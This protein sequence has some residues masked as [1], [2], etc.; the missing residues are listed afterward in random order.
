MSGNEQSGARIESSRDPSGQTLLSIRGRLDSTSAAGVW[1]RLLELGRAAGASGLVVDASA[2]EY[3]DGA[4][5]SL[6]VA[7]ERQQREAGGGFHVRGLREEF[8]KL[9]E[10]IEPA[11]ARV[12]AAPEHREGFFE[13]I[14][15]ATLRLLSDTR[16]LMVFVGELTVML[17]R[18]LR[19]PRQLRFKDLFLVAERAGIGAIPI[20]TL[21]GF[22]LGLILAFQSAIP[23]QRFGAQIFVADLLGISLLRELGPLMA[24][25]LLTARS[26]SAFAAEIGTMK[27]NEEVDALTTMGLEPVSFLAVPRVLAAVVVVPVLAMLTNVAGLAGGALMFQTLDFP[28]VTYVNRV[29][30]ATSLG[31]FVGGLF[32]SFVFGIVVAA[33]GCLRGLQT[34]KGAEAVGESTTSAVVSGIVLIAFIDGIFAVVFY[35]MGI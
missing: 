8:Q 22:L 16:T 21:V 18:A 19:H 10:M 25:I 27:V 6:L 4:G 35:A 3:C 15:R 12:E 34:G 29:V 1:R 17:G 13:G 11:P 23:M 28:L 14:G 24:A 2:L 26:G 31:D 5:A 30:A 33:V 20:V 32:K 7:L 9:V